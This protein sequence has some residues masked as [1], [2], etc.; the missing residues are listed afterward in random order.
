MW[1]VSLLKL[2]GLKCTID[3]VGDVLSSSGAS[4]RLA[5]NNI[6]LLGIDY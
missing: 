4:L 5:I 2:R 1:I 6:S 3:D